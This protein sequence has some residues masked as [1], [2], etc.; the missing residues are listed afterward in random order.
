MFLRSQNS[1]DQAAVGE[2]GVAAA[3]PVV[4]AALR[5]DFLPNPLAEADESALPVADAAAAKAAQFASLRS[6]GS[7]FPAQLLASFGSGSVLPLP[8]LDP[9]VQSA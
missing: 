3:V 7:A 1:G 4:P 2:A 8:G 5:I 6:A 9:P